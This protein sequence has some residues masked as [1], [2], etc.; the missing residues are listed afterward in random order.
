MDG[1]LRLIGW[2]GSA[3]FH[4]LLIMFA[5]S[6]L[7]RAPKYTVTAGAT[8]TEIEFS[9]EDVEPAATPMPAQPPT[10][11]PIVPPPVQ[12]A[13]IAPPI[14]DAFTIPQ[15]P[16]VISP[17]SHPTPDVPRS[18]AKPAPKGRQQSPPSKASQSSN[19]SKGAVAAEPDELHNEPPV[20]P[21]ESRLAHEEGVVILRVEVTVSGEAANVSIQKSSG[22]FRLDQAARQA[23]KQWRFHPGL[24]AGVPVPSAAIVPVNFKL[25]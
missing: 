12:V 4:L 17:L 6:F 25:E 20:Y 7:L 16:A 14:K 23:V 24:L 8:S 15:I 5:T 1:R 9:T 10:L 2:L 18:A 11:P 3:I 22:F 19:A 13:Q 21:D